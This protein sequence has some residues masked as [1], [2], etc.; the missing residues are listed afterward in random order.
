MKKKSSKTKINLIKNPVIKGLLDKFV[1]TVTIILISWAI[2]FLSNYFPSSN[3]IKQLKVDN[4]DLE[5]G[6]D[7]YRSP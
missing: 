4:K 7:Y 1:T 3:T 6:I 5:W 2:G